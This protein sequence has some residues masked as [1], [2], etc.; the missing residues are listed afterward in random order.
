MA[1]PDDNTFR[2]L[3][4]AFTVLGGLM[5]LIWAMLGLRIKKIEDAGDRTSGL[6]QALELRIASDYVP[7]RDL[8]KS[9]DALFRK[10]D[11]IE[12]LLHQKADK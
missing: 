7:R 2:V 1:A 10:L 8:E 9:L 5:S 12:A 3:D 4:W 11:N 6:H